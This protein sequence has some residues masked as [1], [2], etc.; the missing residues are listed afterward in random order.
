MA[1]ELK[2]LSLLTDHFNIV[3]FVVLTHN[4]QIYN[5]T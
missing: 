2:V 4:N 3:I 1:H 5:L